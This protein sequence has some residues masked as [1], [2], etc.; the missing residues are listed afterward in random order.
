MGSGGEWKGVEGMQEPYQ[1][2]HFI[3]LP[4]LSWSDVSFKRELTVCW[5][6]I[7]FG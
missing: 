3:E 6:P 7:K 2:V 5:S 1:S 4:V